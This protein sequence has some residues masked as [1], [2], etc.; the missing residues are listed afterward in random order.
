M[1]PIDK[2]L[3]YEEASTELDKAMAALACSGAMMSEPRVAWH[4]ARMAAES[5][6]KCG[7]ANATT[8]LGVPHLPDLESLQQALLGSPP[9]IE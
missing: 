3:A 1:L 2:L 6:E 5:A 9:T 4:W 7:I 8:L